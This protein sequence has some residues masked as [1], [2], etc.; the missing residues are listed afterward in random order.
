[1]GINTD[2]PDEALSV[3]GNIRVTGRVLTPSDQR[4]KEVIGKVVY[5]NLSLILYLTKWLDWCL[6]VVM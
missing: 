5:N 2:R 4:A 3:H 1:M 6:I